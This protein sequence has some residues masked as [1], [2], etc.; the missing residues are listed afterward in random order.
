M[1]STSTIGVWRTGK[2]TLDL[3]NTFFS[4]ILVKLMRR[5]HHSPYQGAHFGMK[6]HRTSHLP[7]TSVRRSDQSSHCSLST[8]AKK[9]D[10]L[11]DTRI[12]GTNLRLVNLLKAKRKVCAIT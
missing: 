6:C 3:S 8:A 12:F 1:A 10:A 9:V 11:S 4:D 2:V 7:N 5:S